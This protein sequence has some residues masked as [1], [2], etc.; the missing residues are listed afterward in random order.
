MTPK[1]KMEQILSEAKRKHA[2]SDAIAS[3]SQE[4]NNRRD[5]IIKPTSLD[6]QVNQFGV[7]LSILDSRYSLTSH[8]ESQLFQKAQ[9][10]ANY[11]N[12]LIHYGEYDQLR[13]DLR[14]M[15]KHTAP[16]GL[17]IR[18]VNDLAKGVLSPSYRRMDASPIF[19]S[20][21]QASMTE[22]FI[23]YRGHNTDYRYELA[24]IFPELFEIAPN[25][26]VLYGT[27]ILTSDYGAF[28]MQVEIFIMRIW[29]INLAVGY[30]MLRK[31]HLGTR[32]TSDDEITHLSD[33]TYSLDSKTVASA[34]HDMIGYSQI[35]MRS[36][37]DIV[38][39][40]I[41]GDEKQDK[42][43]S[44]KAVIDSLHKKGYRKEIVESIKTSYESELP[45]EALPPVST[46]TWRLSNAISLI[47]K[48]L[49]GDEKLDLEKEAMNVLVA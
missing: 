12:K 14:T 42:V 27:R 48:G 41:E 10:P 31:V 2:M 34:V 49:N 32:F 11:A 1:E 46:G 5:I 45:I 43:T 47:A 18:H 13:C 3:I 28:A 24:F 20:Y 4:F 16:D 23:P 8:S 26:Y 30:D 19:E 22:G 29:C 17:L 9:I 40:R 44:A 21:V 25:E 38:T 15:M 35:Y 37:N 7:K 39:K 33:R 36:L 6:Y